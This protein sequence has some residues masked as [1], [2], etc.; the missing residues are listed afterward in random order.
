[1]KTSSYKRGTMKRIFS[2]MKPYSRRLIISLCLAV[3]IVVTTLFLPVL[4]GKA[5][6]LLLGKGKVDFGALARILSR[7]LILIGITALTQWIM[8]A[9]TNSV[10]Y[11]MVQDLRIQALDHIQKL[12]LS[13][14]DRH[15]H[16]DIV[17]RVITDADQVS[18]GLLMGFS[19]FFTGILTIVLTIV[20][21]FR[22]SPFITLIVLFVTPLSIFAAWFIAKKSFV[23]FKNQ[24]GKRGVMTSVVEEMINGI[25][26]VKAFNHEEAAAEKFERADEELREASLKAVFFSSLT[27]PCTRFVNS[28]VYAGVA[29]F[30]AL[31]A[32]SGSISVGQLTAFLSYANQYTK[33]FNEISGVVT[34]LQNS[35]ACAARLFELIDEKE[36]IPEKTDAEELGSGS[37]SVDINRVAF[38]YTPD[39]PLIE[40]LNLHVKP[41]QRIALVGPTGC[42][43]TTFI[44]LLMRFYDTDSGTICVDG[45]DIRNVKRRSLRSSYGM[46]LQDTWLKSGTVR[47][48]ISMGKPEAT[49]EEIIQAAKEAHADSFIRRLP[50]GYDSVIREDGGNL[51]AGQKQLLCIARVMLTLPPMLILDEATSSIDTRTELKIQDA[52][53][54]MMKGRTSFV[55]AHRL[56]TIRDADMILVMR[57]GHIIEQGKHEELLKKGGFYA[58]LYMAQFTVV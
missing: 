2:L 42:G 58:Q 45:H 31:S 15:S 56:S 32:V 29:L 8:T 1:M 19:Q 52:F 5:V 22:I 37:G 39:K 49:E 51:S 27:N 25:S 36:E 9:V 18:E 34:E 46:V 13:Y 43:K 41:G 24:S 54:G 16:G 14:L 6:D 40:G 47:E 28:L 57:D 26:T 10:A 20:F 11:R 30:G 23:H 17:S 7:M 21:M 38:S 48:N 44:N 55:V 33:P 3:V 12:P 4:T 53:T 50:D 35:V